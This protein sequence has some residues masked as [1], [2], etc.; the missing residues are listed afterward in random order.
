MTATVRWGVLGTGTIAAKLAA[1]MAHAPSARLA[2]VASRDP[3]RAAVFA[4]RFGGA[5]VHETYEALVADPEVDAVYVA[6][7]NALHR[8]HALLAIGAGK[9]VLVEKPFAL[10]AAEARE[11]AEAAR[12]A[13]VFCMEAMWT[14]FLPVIA[15]AKRIVDAGGIGRPTLVRAA[16][17]F[18]APTD[19]A[20]RFNDPALGGGALLDLG[21][22]GVSM[23]H[24]FLGAPLAISAHVIE[25][26][27]GIDRQIAAL[28]TY[29]DAAAEVTASHDAPLTNGLEI[30]GASGR[31]AVDPPFQQAARARVMTFA[32]PPA[33]ATPKP[34]GLA[35]MALKRTG[36]W[37]FAR[38]ATR[39]LL[40]YDGRTI[41][42]GFPGEGL[43]FELEE[44]ARRIAAGEIES[45]VAPLSDTVA[46][47]ETMD[48]IRAAAVQTA[49]GI[50]AIGAKV[51]ETS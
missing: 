37:P 33:A 18:P 23:A 19:P 15:E 8:D 35:K 24:L 36:L 50:G 22:Y 48:R 9:P 1:D 34:D 7:P 11:I 2:A 47:M 43:Q 32:A 27:S 5:R 49:H 14:R 4:A 13:G 29:A 45:P 25:G 21:I 46:V 44:V 28:L 17:G 20:S 41:R 51:E 39:R 38:A 26:L 6:T 12:S 16:L 30:V 31:V 42:G 40:G 10:D 3:A